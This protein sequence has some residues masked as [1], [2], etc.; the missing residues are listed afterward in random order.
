MLR[1][2]QPVPD[3]EHVPMPTLLRDV[4]PM[5]EALREL[6]QLQQTEER[7]EHLT[8]ITTVPT[9][10]Q[11]TDDNP[12]HRQTGD[13]PQEPARDAPMLII[14]AEIP[15][16]V[17]RAVLQIRTSQMKITTAEVQIVEEPIVII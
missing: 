14:R 11:I 3:E 16:A 13:N 1:P 8:A 2:Q 7:Q 15:I 10:V 12:V 5:I 6:H 17:Q 9:A 4:K